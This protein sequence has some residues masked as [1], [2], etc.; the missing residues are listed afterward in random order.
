MPA[1][2]S[3][4][5]R[6][7]ARLGGAV[8]DV[9]P[10]VLHRRHSFRSA[11]HRSRARSSEP[12]RKR[13]ASAAGRGCR[14]SS[15]TARASTSATAAQTGR[16]STTVAEFA[17][18]TP[19]RSD[20]AA[21][22]AH[23][24][25]LHDRLRARASVTWAAWTRRLPRPVVACRAS[26]CR[27]DRLGLPASRPA[28]IRFRPRRVAAHRA[29]RRGD[30]RSRSSTPR[31]S[32]S[33]ATSCS[34][35]RCDR[36][37]SVGAIHV[38]RPG[39]LTT[40]QDLGRWGHQASGVPVAGPMDTYSHRLA[41]LLV[42]NAPDA[43]GLEI[44]LLG[45]DL[46]FD[47]A[48]TVAICGA[49]FDMTCDGHAVPSGIAVRRPGGRRVCNS[50]GAA[51]GAPRVSRHCRRV[52]DA[53]GSRKPRDTTGQRDGRRRR[54]GADRRR[55]AAVRRIGAEPATSTRERH[56]H[57]G[58]RACSAAAAARAAGGQLRAGGGAHAGRR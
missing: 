23:L 12:C 6:L 47:C 38:R 16:T 24:P 35:F 15:G 43:A 33:R 9:V 52:A 31:A 36:D 45:P 46:E 58:Q 39:L 21:F 57:P 42:G 50:A 27:P 25:R 44:T 4:R 17:G 11:A 13:R 1:R 7:R 8:R 37:M 30:V 22:D 18:C 51:S 3:W 41:N 54:A 5:Q 34:S 2:F 14:Q 32:C 56:D 49:E 53:A 10:S 26:G 19:R 48:A 28:C 29:H 20:R 40:V 55:P